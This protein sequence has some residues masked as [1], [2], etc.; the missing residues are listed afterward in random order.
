MSRNKKVMLTPRKVE[1]I[2]L[3]AIMQTMLLAASYLMDELDYSEDRLLAFWAGV[4]R[5][6]Q[7][8]KDHDIT[9]NKV[10]LILK[11]HTGLEV[12]WNK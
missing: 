8:V 12:R 7:A 3:E 6:S 5:Y 1:D 10:C 11:E 4:T 2:K 9:M